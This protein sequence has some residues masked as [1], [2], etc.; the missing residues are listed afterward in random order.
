M[1]SALLFL[2]S[3]IYCI[4]ESEILLLVGKVSAHSNYMEKTLN[5]IDLPTSPWPINF[6]TVTSNR[7]HLGVNALFLSAVFTFFYGSI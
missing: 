3:S 1:H 2:A 5:L 6:A 4:I 7:T